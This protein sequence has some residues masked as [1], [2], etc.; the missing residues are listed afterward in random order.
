MSAPGLVKKEFDQPEMISIGEAS[1]A[2]FL[3]LLLGQV[4]D[5]RHLELLLVIGL[6][7]QV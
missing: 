3:C 4:A 1:E 6:V 5:E 2:L 7:H